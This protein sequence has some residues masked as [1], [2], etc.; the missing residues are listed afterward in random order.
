VGFAPLPE[1]L[2][3]AH[4]ALDRAVFA[5]YGWDPEMT[6]DELLAAL[7]ELNLNMGG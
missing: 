4:D 2:R 7:L 6:D 1:W 5:A 3:S